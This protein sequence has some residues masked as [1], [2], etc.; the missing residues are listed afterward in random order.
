MN[1]AR[2][3]MG[4]QGTS[5]R[6]RVRWSNALAPIRNHTAAVGLIQSLA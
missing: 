4:S 3:M 5:W 6:V 2:K 1:R